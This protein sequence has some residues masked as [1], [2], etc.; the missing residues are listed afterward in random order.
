M[1]LMYFWSSILD[2]EDEE[3]EEDD[4]DDDDDSIYEYESKMEKAKC[5]VNRKR[6]AS[7]RNYSILSPSYE[8]AMG[9]C[10]LSLEFFELLVAK[11]TP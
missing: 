3:E 9:T 8:V 2:V 4:E 6:M 7:K 5:S 1:Y 10:N 11:I